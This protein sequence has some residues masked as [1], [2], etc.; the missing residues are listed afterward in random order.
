MVRTPRR[1][2]NT[3]EFFSN[4]FKSLNLF[5]SL[6]NDVRAVDHIKTY[7]SIRE[8]H[9]SGCYKTSLLSQFGKLHLGRAGEVYGELWQLDI[10]CMTVIDILFELLGTHSDLLRWFRSANW[11]S[12]SLLSRS[13]DFKHYKSSERSGV[14]E[15]TGT[16]HSIQEGF[17]KTDMEKNVGKY[18]T[19]CR[20]Y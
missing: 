5:N 8:V 10:L 19:G 18:D 12:L 9:V 17:S 14:L 15:V 6:H 3:L 13:Y 16:M 4:I 20:S 1:S 11:Q 7:G 2:V